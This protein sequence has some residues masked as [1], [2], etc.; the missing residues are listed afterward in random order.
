MAVLFSETHFHQDFYTLPDG[1]ITSKAPYSSWESYSKDFARGFLKKVEHFQ[2]TENT[3]ISQIEKKFL[4][5]NKTES[6]EKSEWFPCV[7]IFNSNVS[8]K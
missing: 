7:K 4:V 2:L 3:Q 1:V 6:G 5:Y 8:L